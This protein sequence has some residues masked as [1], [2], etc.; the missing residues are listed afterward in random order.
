MLARPALHHRHL[1]AVGQ[2]VGDTAALHD[3]TA[4]AQLDCHALVEVAGRILAAERPDRDLAADAAL[5][6]AGDAVAHALA[7][8]IKLVAG[9]DLAEAP[10]CGVVVAA[11]AV[12]DV[13]QRA[14]APAAAADRLL[15]L[16]RAMP[17]VHAPAQRRQRA[18]LSAKPSS[19]ALAARMKSIRSFISASMLGW[20]A[21][22]RATSRQNA[23]PIECSTRLVWATRSA[24]LVSSLCARA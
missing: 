15:L 18:A 8:A 12:V 10:D 4:L 19:S 13:R 23:S 3:H 20:R 16:Q 14:A 7:L 21:K 22:K 24:A 1:V 11:G 5:L 2:P 6:V 17:L 9:L